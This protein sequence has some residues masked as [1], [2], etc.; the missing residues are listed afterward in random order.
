MGR[1]RLGVVEDLNL[2]DH[3]DLLHAELSN[4]EAAKEALFAGMEK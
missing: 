2:D 4:Y 1:G 3:R